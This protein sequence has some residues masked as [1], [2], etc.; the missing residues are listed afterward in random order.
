VRSLALLLC[1]CASPTTPSSPSPDAAPDTAIVNGCAPAVPRA[2][3]TC[4]RYAF[5]L[6]APRDAIELYGTIYVTEMSAGRV[7]K[8]TDSGF[9]AVATGLTS[10]IGIRALDGKLIVS[11]EGARRVSRIDPMSGA[12]DVLAK[13]L[14]NVTY[15]T[16]GPDSVPYVSSFTA[17]DAPT[18]VVKRI[19]DSVTDFVTGVNV[20]EGLAFDGD[21]LLVVE[22]G[23]PSRVTRHPPGTTFATGFDRAYGIAKSRE[24]WFVADTTAGVVVEVLP[25]GTRPV[26]SN[27]ATPAGLSRTANG[28]LLVVEHGSPNHNATGYLLRVSGLP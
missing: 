8:L 12:V 20:P 23:K 14:G 11:E 5:P 21:T 28:D 6:A 16:I 17:L 24:G 18:A 22:W 7:V 9:V 19:G 25:D 10:P 3:V 26:L 4:T 13:D 1:S 15:L 2:G 27:A